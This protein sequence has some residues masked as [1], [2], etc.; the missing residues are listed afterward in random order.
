MEELLK[1]TAREIKIADNEINNNNI[2]VKIGTVEKRDKPD[3]IYIFIS[4]WLKPKNEYKY[5]SQEYLKKK[6]SKEL[7]S[8]YESNIKDILKNNKYFPI[9]EENI[10][11]KNIPENL[12]YNN[13]SNFISIELYLHTLNLLPEVE[14][15]F[16]LNQKK[17]TELY[18]EALKISNI[19]SN[20]QVLKDNIGFTIKRKSNE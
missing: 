14:K 9:P 12:N 11:I 4:F 8:I 15:K 2:N 19:I 1:K 5:K 17:N 18:D 20:T 7:S 3:T 10:F 16:P 13:K 6:L